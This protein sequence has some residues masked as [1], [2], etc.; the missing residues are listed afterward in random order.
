MKILFLFI[1]ICLLPGFVSGQN[2]SLED[3][4]SRF[5]E[6]LKKVSDKKSAQI[7]EVKIKYLAA[8]LRLEVNARAAGNLDLVKAARTEIS[9]VEQDQGLKDFMET[10]PDELQEMQRVVEN[11]YQQYALEEAA[12]VIRL[13]ESL[14]QYAAARSVE[15]TRQNKIQDAQNWRDW[16][17]S[18]QENQQVIDAY[19]FQKEHS[20]P[21][22]NISG[23]NTQPFHAALEGT[24]AKIQIEKA[25]SFSETPM[26]YQD[27]SEPIGKE[28]RIQNAVTPNAKGS[29][30]TKITAQVLLIDDD[31]TLTNNRSYFSQYK[32][33][34]HL[35]V[36][37][38][39]LSPLVGKSLDRC[40]VVFDLYKRGT[41]SKR[42]VITTDKILIP[43]LSARE[44]VVV[45]A[46]SY[47]Y[48]TQEYDPRYSSYGYK[49]STADEFYGYIV[50]IFDRDG[51]MIYQRATE[52]ALK[53][54]ARETPPN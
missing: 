11:L 28:K 53:E 45:D 23:E 15:S 43:P 21:E 30:H 6:E 49:N 12:M 46:G 44:K 16:E 29:G 52:R 39:K 19:A 4:D 25:K 3:F 5:H 1:S 51:E 27:K 40:L 13:T 54:Y 8:L 38:I 9:R 35:Y 24:P 33:K 31:E 32:E 18:L 7:Q 34:A 22:Q 14:K 50:T 47:S 42:S 2:M 17:H 10:G 36:P 37:R 26:V 41:G 20:G 48:E